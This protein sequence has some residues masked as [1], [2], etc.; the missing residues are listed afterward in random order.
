MLSQ[1]W[2]G[3]WL[4][5]WKKAVWSQWVSFSRGKVNTCHKNIGYFLKGVE[6]TVQK[7]WF[8]WKW[9]LVNIWLSCQPV[10]FYLTNFHSEILSPHAITQLVNNTLLP[11][12][13]GSVRPRKSRNWVKRLV[14]LLQKRIFLFLLIFRLNRGFFYSR[15]TRGL[16]LENFWWKEIVLN[17]NSNWFL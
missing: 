12:S 5:V 6:I 7:S 3:F 10:C 1:S 14:F 4:K 17:L 9:S 2:P 13:S 16:I 11:S 8:W 15:Y